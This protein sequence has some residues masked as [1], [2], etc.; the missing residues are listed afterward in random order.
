M[1]G[2]PPLLYDAYYHIYNRGINHENIF[3]E[4]RNYAYFMELYDRYIG[5]IVDT[6]AYC[7]LR[8]HFHLLVRIKSEEEINQTLKVSEIKTLKVSETFRVSPSNQFSKFF[9]AYAKAINKAYARTGSLFQQPFGRVPVI[10]PDQFERLVI[11]IHKNPEKHN[12]VENY[13]E[14]K[15]SSYTE[16]LSGP[17]SRL[18][19]EVVIGWFGDFGE[20]QR[21]HDVEDLKSSRP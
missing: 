2:P 9:N 1:P 7:L 19:R 11:C 5:P 6:Y 4:E 13:R 21:L 18:Q 12:F 20:F 10:D 3:V 14:W 15:Y 16:L 17:T 8:N